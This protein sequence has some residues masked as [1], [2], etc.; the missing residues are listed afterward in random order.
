MWGA[1]RR[2]ATLANPTLEQTAISTRLVV[3]VQAC[4]LAMEVG[5]LRNSFI[6]LFVHRTDYS[7]TKVRGSANGLHR[8][9]ELRLRRILLYLAMLYESCG[10]FN[11]NMTVLHCCPCCSLLQIKLQWRTTKC[12]MTSIHMNSHIKAVHFE[13][14][15]WYG[16]LGR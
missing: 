4:V 3:F 15:T 2:C 8:Y 9:S 13:I 1:W 7:H 16:P 14:S 6:Y 10:N 5:V 11:F 12:D